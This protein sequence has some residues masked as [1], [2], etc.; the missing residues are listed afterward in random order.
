MLYENLMVLVA[1][2]L[3]TLVG[4]GPAVWLTHGSKQTPRGAV[5]LAPTL[6]L[7]ILNLLGFPFVRYVGAIQDWS[8]IATA[9]LVL[10]SLTLVVGYWKYAGL[11]IRAARWKL[12]T[13]EIVFV[14]ACLIVL[15]APLALNG[16]QYA[17][18]RSNP[19]DAFVYLSL[20]E[21]ARVADWS[22]IAQ[23][24][25]FTRDNWS[26]LTELAAASPT[27]LF[28]ARLIGLSFSLNNSITLAWLGSLFQIPLY[29]FFVAFNLFCLACA[30]PLALLICK[31]L[32]LS[33]WLIYLGAAAI[34]LGFWG[35]YIVESDSSGEIASLPL[36]MLTVLAWMEI[37][38]NEGRVTIP[39]AFL[40]AIPLAATWCINFPIVGL[41][42]GGMAF[43]YGIALVRRTTNL[44]KIVRLAIPFVLAFGILLVTGQLEYIWHNTLRG[45]NSVGTQALFGRY[46]VEMLRQDHVSTLWGM[47]RTILWQDVHPFL[48]QRLLRWTAL[49]VSI[50]IAALAVATFLYFIGNK[51][52]SGERIIVSIALTGLGLF[53]LLFAMKNGHSAGKALTYAF[54][55]LM[56]TPLMAYEHLPKQANRL[57]QPAL[58]A[59][60]GVWLT[61]QIAMSF[62]IPYAPNVRG[63]FSAGKNFKDEAFDLAP[64]L[65]TLDTVQPTR[66]LV[67][68]PRDKDW[69]FAYYVMFA[70]SKYNPHFQSGLVIDNNVRYQN[71]WFREVMQAPDFAVVLRS[72]DFIGAQQLGDVVGS[73][74]DL[75][76]YRVTNP[77]VAVWQAQEKSFQQQD[78]AKPLFETLR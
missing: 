37:E 73:T 53:A 5:Y 21:T 67:A 20:A 38:A 34:V 18:F 3:A 7:A 48:L 19:S 35:R 59:L 50:G 51:L 66:L 30:L 43:Y 61:G 74:P 62:F 57:V 47:P 36:L 10:V 60:V 22:T 26:G 32:A 27:A 4:L 71:L 1:V 13:W 42:V 17:I 24:T 44:S 31:R 56:L 25:A 16:I 39:N 63:V 28:S 68:V 12:F 72:Q 52:K 54:P 77:D 49:A 6:G 14:L 64:I 69:T 76:L 70:F 15:T 58:A 78:A 46:V 29:R 65:A 33:R 8:G 41:L 2:L 75:L 55:Y 40:F 9:G 23:G 45:L 11:S